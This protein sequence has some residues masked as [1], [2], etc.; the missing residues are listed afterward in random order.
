MVSKNFIRTKGTLDRS[1]SIDF[2]KTQLAKIKSAEDFTHNGKLLV[3]L[4]SSN[5]DESNSKNWISVIY[6]SPFAGSTDPSIVDRQAFQSYSGTQKSYGF[7]AVPP[8]VNNYVLVTF[9]NGDETQG[10]WFACVYKDTLTHMVPGIGQDK[11]Y[12]GATGPVAEMN[13]FSGQIGN[14]KV[15]PNRPIY[16]PLNSG[17]ATQGLTSDLLRGAGTS[18]VW[19]DNT[20]AVCGILTPGGNQFVLDDGTNSKLIRLRTQSGAQILISE[21]EGH[22]YM[23]NKTGSGW[24]EL[25]NDGNILVYSSAGISFRS[26]GNINFSAGGDI[27]MNSAGKINIGNGGVLSIRSGTRLN[28]FGGTDINTVTPISTGYQATPPTISGPT[29]IPT[30]EPYTRP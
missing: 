9:A 15:N 26:D 14:P 12:N 20:P 13:I 21:T 30:H 18:S 23:I 8:D 22:V 19:R 3:W 28:I 17:L 6:A 5:T 25:N 29:I 11:S 27:N 24:V 4:T 1:P 2:N 16:T 7:F 10:F